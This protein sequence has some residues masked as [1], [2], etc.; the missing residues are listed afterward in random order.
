MDALSLPFLFYCLL[1][2]NGFPCTLTSIRLGNAAFGAKEYR[3][4]IQHYTDA[5]RLDSTNHVFYS[6]RS[7]CYCGLQQWSKAAADAKECIRLDP[8]FVKGYYRLVTAQVELQ[9]YTGAAAT[10][11]QGLSVDESNPQLLKQQRTVQQMKRAA[12]NMATAAAKQRQAQQMQ[13]QQQSTAASSMATAPATGSSELEQ[14]QRQYIQTNRDL[15]ALKMNLAQRERERKVSEITKNE[16]LQ[17]DNESTP[18]K[19]NNKETGYYRSVGKMFLR[20]SR[21]EVVS[22]LDQSM[23]ACQQKENELKHQSE[24]LQRQV[25]SQRQNMQEL[26]NA[27]ASSSAE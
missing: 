14:L 22:Y 10:I 27:T 5:I 26:V 11:R 1:L 7:A 2:I 8:T 25:Q 9:D 6:N 15:E 21:D 20:T 4:A 17:M 23:T 19:N 24:Y 18:S 13:A 16:V 3:Q 12:E